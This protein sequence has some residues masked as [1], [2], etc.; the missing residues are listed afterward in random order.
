MR[1]VLWD[2]LAVQAVLLAAAIAGG[3]WW[4]Y[5]VFWL[6]PY[7]TVWRVINRLRSIAE[8][9]G[10]EFVRRCRVTPAELGPLAGLSGA[11]AL[12]LDDL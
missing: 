3:A 7:L 8:H 10:M 6:L 12:V 5:P 2:I 4:V 9:G 1:R 11:A